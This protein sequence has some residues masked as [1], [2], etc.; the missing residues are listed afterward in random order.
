LVETTKAWGL[1]RVF[2]KNESGG[3]ASLPIAWTDIKPFDPFVKMGEG[4]AFLHSR[5]AIH[6]SNLLSELLGKCV[7]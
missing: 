6:L 4:R 2:F 3:L 7:K 1:E 5:D